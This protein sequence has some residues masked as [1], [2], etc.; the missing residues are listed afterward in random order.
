MTCARSLNISNHVFPS[1]F[2]GAR[3]D[4]SAE[5]DAIA[6]IL[7]ECPARPYAELI[8]S[9]IPG[10]SSLKPARPAALRP[11]P[12][13]TMRVSPVGPSA[14]TPT[15]GELLAQLETLSQKPWS[16][17]RKTSS[18]AEKGRPALAKVPKLGASSSSPSTPVQKPEWAPS[19]A[20]EAP[21]VLS[22]RPPSKSAA[23][24][25]N[26]LGG[27]IEQPLA[28]VP[29]TVWNPPTESV[30]SPPRQAEE[31]KKKTLESKI[32]KDGDSLLLNAELA[33][34]AVSSILKDSD[35][36]RSKAL[37]VDEALALSL[38]GVASVSP[39][40]LSCLLPC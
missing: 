16:V 14:A 8:K 12:S 5:D 37:P 35:L 24:A 21:I 13:S 11:S 4:L 3:I 6:W 36:G 40:V 34:G 26:L 30:R 15:R 39:C 33:T 18:F 38:Q 29:I 27:S 7:A 31:L 22:S 9:G 25:K 23:K 19:P 17:K 20:T 32:S 2:S 10:P 1:C 28:V